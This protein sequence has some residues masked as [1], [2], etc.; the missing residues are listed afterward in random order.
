MDRL[1]DFI[2]RRSKLVVA[3]TLLITVVGL[4]SLSR[5]E[6][7]PDFLSLYS[8]TSPRAEQYNALNEK[9]GQRESVAVLVEQ[10][11]P[12]LT[13]EGLITALQLQR[14]IE[15]IDG[16]SD[17]QSYIP[18]EIVLNGEAVPV[19][20]AL[21]REHHAL[22]VGFIEDRYFYGD[23]L[24]S[25]DRSNGILVAG[26]SLDASA[27]PVV[28]S[29][30]ALAEEGSG[31]ALSFAG[32]EIVRDELRNSIRTV[33]FY[34][35]PL[36][37]FL[38]LLVFV[39]VIR[40]V[41]LT[42]LA[43]LPAVLAVLWMYGTILWSGHE[44][45]AV[46]SVAPMFVLVLGTVYGLHYVS[47]LIDSS[48]DH[49]DRRRATVAALG[50]VGWP[51]LLATVTTVAGF[52]A[53][54]WT[55]IIPIRSLG[56]FS[57]IGIL[58]AGLL[59]LV[60]LPALLSMVRISKMPPRVSHSRVARLVVAMSRRRIPISAAFLVIV[61][62]SAFYIPRLEVV[63]HRLMY[64]E[65]D[66][67]IMV[68]Y[69]KLEDAFGWSFT[70]IGEVA[71]DGGVSALADQDRAREV[72]AVERELESLPFV[73][74]ALSAFD[75]VKGANLMVTGQDEYPRDLGIISGLAS[76]MSAEDIASWISSDG[77]R[78]IV[79]TEELS[80]DDVS[81]L[82][83]FV[84]DHS[85]SIR[86]VTGV[87]ML[88][89]DLNEAVTEGQVR[90][91]ALAFGLIFIIL[92]A[93]L[94]NLRAAV[95]GL[96][97]IVITVL[98]ILGFL[99]LTNTHLHFITAILSAISIGVGVDYCIHVLLGVYTFRR[100]GLSYRESVDGAL[101]VVAGPVLANAVGITIGLCTLFFAPL[102]LYTDVAAVLC[103]AMLLSAMGALLL[104]P[105]FYSSGRNP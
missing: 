28:E 82:A 39:L 72:L 53:L 32:D 100:N 85:D 78:L 35:P 43:M 55:D 65:E 90:S 20:E 15:A 30:R 8:Q 14:D 70:L 26:L 54:T 60:F 69:S 94:R 99:A 87:P 31:L 104:I 4:A 45:T 83:A 86:A 46:T 76:Q 13:P 64:F 101:S 97:P 105:Q 63:Y 21:V 80:S 92:L 48:H 50:M 71:A 12:L 95:S 37:V 79:R 51:L 103:V 56:I 7:D 88:L 58:Y 62:L 23:Q 18:P 84:E 1:A 77:F 6:L 9:Y 47:H 49:P 40:S 34:L 33:L 91:L 24:L 75:L 59:A 73:G 11:S 61:G 2:Y 22:V 57:A 25:S 36:A 96:L 41:R 68:T 74:S 17:V 102:K 67:E 3:I 10:E 19:D 89:E 44:V 5:F 98:G 93:T 16:V 66:S 52:A 29:L 38:I 42:L 27:A 81:Q